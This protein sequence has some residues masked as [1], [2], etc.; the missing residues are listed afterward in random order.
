MRCRCQSTPL[1]AG[2]EVGEADNP[3]AIIQSMNRQVVYYRGEDD[4]TDPI[5]GYLNGKYGKS[6]DPAAK[7]RAAAAPAATAPA[8]R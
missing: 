1:R 6:G 7:P 5:L 2:D 8:T 4:L 3:Q